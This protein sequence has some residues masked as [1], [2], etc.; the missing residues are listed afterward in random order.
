[1]KAEMA[2]TSAWYGLFK[3]SANNFKVVIPAQAGIQQY[4]STVL[5]RAFN[6]F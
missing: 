4:S 1:M 3:I 2:M 6:K 5:Q